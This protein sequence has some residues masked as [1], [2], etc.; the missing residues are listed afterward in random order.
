MKKTVLTLLSAVT[1]LTAYGQETGDT[2]IVLNY[3]YAPID[4][5]TISK[6]SSTYQQ[7]QEAE[8][9]V[10]GISDEEARSHAAV[11]YILSHPDSEGSIWLLESVR[12]FTKGKKC[13]SVL[14]ERVK[15]GAMK[16]V[17]DAYSDGFSVYKSY[18]DK[19]AAAIPI[20][21]EAKDFTL[22]DINGKMLTLSSLRG[23]YVLL[24]FW[25]SWCVPCAQMFP[26]VKEFYKQHRDKLE[27]LGVA[28]R[29][30]K[31]KWK[32]AAEKH[33]LPW[34]LVLDTEDENSVKDKYCI[35]GL[36]TYVLLDPEGKVVQWTMNEFELI[37]ECL[38]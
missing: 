18:M 19:T 20:G 34:Q 15:K 26:H 30:K 32:A 35:F 33:Q 25:A 37:E 2:T 36:P 12:G 9:A 21:Q 6:T 10:K 24:D 5:I 22:E 11:D 16:K 23:K 17:Y 27:I 7:L 28:I 3:G 8:A 31:D 38:K 1:M 13:F 29:D 4:T 14:S